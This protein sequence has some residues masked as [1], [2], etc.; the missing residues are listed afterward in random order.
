M[1]IF[2]ADLTSKMRSCGC[3]KPGVKRH[4]SIKQYNSAQE[5]IKLA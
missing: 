2:S 5:F 4:H 3:K 1:Q